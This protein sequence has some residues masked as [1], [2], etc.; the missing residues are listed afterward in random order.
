MATRTFIP[1]LLARWGP[2]IA[3]MALIF[4]LSSRSRVPG[5]GRLPDLV[6][7]GIG[8]LVLSFLVTRALSLGPRLGSASLL[9]AVAVATLYGVSDEIHQAFVPGRHPDPWDVGK[10][11]L[12]AVVGALAYQW[13]APRHRLRT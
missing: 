8:Y 9:L 5:L 12:G 13:I 10:D 4:A 3:W 2:A 11:A 1:R 6:T 7:H